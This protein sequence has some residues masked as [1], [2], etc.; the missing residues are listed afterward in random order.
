MSRWRR[1]LSSL[2]VTLMA[3]ICLSASAAVGQEK[4]PA[5][6]ENAIQKLVALAAELK[7]DQEFKD[8]RDIADVMSFSYDVALLKLKEP[9][10]AWNDLI[11]NETVLVVYL[12]C[13]TIQYPA[14]PANR[15]GYRE[16]VVEFRKFLYSGGFDRMVRR[17]AILPEF[18]TVRYKDFEEKKP[19]KLSEII[20]KPEEV[21]NVPLLRQIENLRAR[22]RLK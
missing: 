15:A 11:K 12:N 4:V 7:I 9:F 8:Y 2:V 20:A 6:L 21:F 22:F 18:F 1:G 14:L 16:V 17:V 3:W 10:G 13:P 5:P 19:K